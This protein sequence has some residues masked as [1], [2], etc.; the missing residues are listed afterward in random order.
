MRK[1]RFEEANLRRLEEGGR[2]Q[3]RLKQTVLTFDLKSPTPSKV[4]ERV[5][6]GVY[7]LAATSESSHEE[8]ETVW[9]VYKINNPHTNVNDFCQGIIAKKILRMLQFKTE[10]NI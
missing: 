6:G 7:P 8:E 3:N 4:R 5:A 1:A 9:R 10:L 2:P